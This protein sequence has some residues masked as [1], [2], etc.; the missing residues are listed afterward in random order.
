MNENNFCDFQELEEVAEGIVKIFC[1]IP[2]G[3]MLGMYNKPLS[4]IKA[5]TFLT[6]DMLGKSQNEMKTLIINELEKYK[7]SSGNLY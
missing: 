7:L 5:N 2:S 3:I 6:N 1:L 4:L